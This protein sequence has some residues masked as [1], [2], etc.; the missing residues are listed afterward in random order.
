MSKKKRV[1]Q[2]SKR[3]FR[4]KKNYKKKKLSLIDVVE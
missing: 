3:K 2:R 4:N 1:K